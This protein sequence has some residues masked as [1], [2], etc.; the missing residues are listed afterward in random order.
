MEDDIKTIKSRSFISVGS[1]L[2]QSS[3]SAALGF[4]AFFILTLRSGVYLLGIYNTVLAMMSFFNYITNLGLAA[5]IVQKKETTEEDLSTAFFLQFS[6]TVIGVI[7]GFLLTGFLFKFYKDLPPEAVYL[8]WAVLGSFFLL[9]LKT[10]PSVL[11]EKSIQIYKVVLV[12]AVENT[13]FYLSVIIFSLMGLEIYSLV[14]A[15]ILR[16]VF[17]VILIYYFKPWRPKLIFSV[18]S[19][20][21]LLKFGLPFQG[22]SFLALI[23]DDLLIIYLG[24][25]IGLKN[26]GYVTFAKKYGEFSLR[27]IMDN[28]NRVAFPLFSRFQKDKD[29]LRKSVERVLYYESI[30]IFP[31]TIGALFIFDNLLRLIPGYYDKWHLALFSFYFFSLS[32][33]FVSL[34]SPFTN[35]FNAIGRVKTSL[36]L[37]VLWTTLTWLLIPTFIKFFG[38]NGISIA[39]FV[40]SLTFV[41]VISIAYKYV[42]F[43]FSN[44]IKTSLFA[45][46]VMTLYLVLIRFMFTRFMPNIYLDLFF[47]VAGASFIYFGVVYLLKGKAAYQELL[48]FFKPK[49]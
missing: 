32:A 38:Y 48:E 41:L 37:M 46:T 12:Q 27:L 18:K 23:K 34:S 33:F 11:L 22:N 43:S 6:L 30:L 19:A 35:L 20:K 36:G 10:I 49:K 29:L 1:L 2:L 15:V 31:I 16:A 45:T 13:L 5:A 24:S 17:G 44:S 9:S 42:K 39:F 14:I 4:T 7:V 8:Y 3:Y 21:A 28:M 47:S 40:Q 26:L 25:A